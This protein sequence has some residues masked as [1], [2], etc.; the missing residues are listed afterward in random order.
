MEI[1]LLQWYH[2]TR[3][4]VSKIPVAILKCCTLVGGAS[5]VMLVVKSLP[6]NTGDTGSISGSGRSPGRG[7]ENPLQYSC[8]ENPYGQRS[9]AVYSPWGHKELGMTDRL[10]PAQHRFVISFLPRNKCLLTSWLQS[11][12]KVIL[13]PKKIKSVTASSFPSSICY[14]V[15]GPDAIILVF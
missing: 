5:Q 3:F 2:F 15:M 12:S 11:L 14:E 9:L 4:Q 8:L 13:E 1:D 10:S 7:H 6:V